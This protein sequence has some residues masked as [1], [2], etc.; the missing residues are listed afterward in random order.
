MYS[1]EIDVLL[2]VPAQF[3]LSAVLAHCPIIHQEEMGMETI[4]NI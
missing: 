1:L 3:D 4:E 2:Q